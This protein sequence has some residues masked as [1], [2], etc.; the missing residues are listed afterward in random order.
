MGSDG[1]QQHET[2]VV[3]ASDVEAC[4]VR[5]WTRS[6]LQTGF[7]HQIPLERKIEGD[8]PSGSCICCFLPKKPATNRRKAAASAVTFPCNCSQPLCCAHL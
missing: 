2:Y 8:G 4:V 7:G 1:A 6:Q 5:A 3:E